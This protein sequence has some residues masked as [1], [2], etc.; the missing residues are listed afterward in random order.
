MVGEAVGEGDA[1]PFFIHAQAG[2]IAYRY[3]TQD[4]GE[5][6][7]RFDSEISLFLVVEIERRVFVRKDGD[8][9]HFLLNEVVVMAV[10]QSVYVTERGDGET[11]FWVD[12]FQRQPVVHY[13][14]AFIGMSGDLFAENRFLQDVLS[15]A[16]RDIGEEMRQVV[17]PVDSEG[18]VAFIVQQIGI[19][20]FDF[21]IMD[22]AFVIELVQDETCVCFPV[23]EVL[24]AG[25]NGCRQ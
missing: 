17:V 5:A 21:D 22:V 7:V 23:L 13:A 2:G 15:D 14:Y 8:G 6:L 10:R 25:R 18:T 12:R 1:V 24:P 16:F 19:A 20:V 9:A 4:A 11:L 3:F